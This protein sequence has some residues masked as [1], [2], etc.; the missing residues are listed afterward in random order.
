MDDYRRSLTP[1]PF[2]EGKNSKFLHS[3][4]Q[5][6]ANGLDIIFW[7]MSGLFVMLAI[8]S[9]SANVAW[10]ITLLISAILVCPLVPIHFVA[11]LCLATFSVFPPSLSLSMIVV[12]G[13]LWLT[14][15]LRGPANDSSDA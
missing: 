2:V 14:T 10:A 5:W 6:L 15:V 8:A 13:V 7:G 11:K 3:S 4:S 12:L 1:S 9:F